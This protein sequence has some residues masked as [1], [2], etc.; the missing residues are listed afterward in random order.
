MKPLSEVRDELAKEHVLQYFDELD[1][2][3]ENAIEWVKDGFDAGVEEM[4]KRAEV[5][6]EAYK[7]LLIDLEHYATPRRDNNP[8]LPGH[9]WH[10]IKIK[11]ESDYEYYP[12]HILKEEVDDYKNALEQYKKNTEG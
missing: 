12:N 7:N 6:V 9:E 11:H 2:E 3:T 10:Y 5:L 8:A 1:E 4:K